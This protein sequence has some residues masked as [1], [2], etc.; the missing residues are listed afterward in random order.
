MKKSAF[1]LLMLGGWIGVAS[2]Q[3]SVTLYGIL[4]LSIAHE[5]NGAGSV[6]K[7]ES[8]VY[9][10]GRVG[11]RGT[12]DLGGGLSAN[13]QL[14]MGVNADDGTS[15]QGGILFGRQAWVPC[16]QGASTHRSTWR[17]CRSTPSSAA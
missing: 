16:G 11:M 10:G 12:E 3:S 4:D 1:A 6:T 17:N 15:A 14:E 8:G 5:S 13:F 2:A 9:N 7:M